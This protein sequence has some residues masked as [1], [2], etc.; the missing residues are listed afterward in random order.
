MLSKRKASNLR[1]LRRSE[2][3]NKFIGILCHKRQETLLEATLY[4]LKRK[5]TFDYKRSFL[6]NDFLI[7]KLFSN[8]E[9]FSV[10]YE[11]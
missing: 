4:A 11:F 10:C 9:K 8:Y 2:L 6:E 5:F 7:Q 3:E 1:I